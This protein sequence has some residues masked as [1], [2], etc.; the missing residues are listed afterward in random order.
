MRWDTAIDSAL[1]A[2]PP[3]AR[4]LIALSLRGTIVPRLSQHWRIARLMRVLFPDGVLGSINGE[5]FHVPGAAAIWYRDFEPLTCQVVESCL[6]PD[7]TF[8]DVGR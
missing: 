5:A 8:V 2:Y 4:W 1:L 3:L 7:T 6:G